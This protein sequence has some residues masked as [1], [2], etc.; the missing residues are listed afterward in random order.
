MAEGKIVPYLD[1]P[2]QHASTRILKAMRRPRQCGEYAGAIR[3]WRTI[4]PEAHL[5][6]TFHRRLSRRNRS[7]IEE[8]L[9]SW[10]KAS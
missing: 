3:A 10:K 6:S 8:L 1:V 7:R 9:S 5:R 2:F 4:C